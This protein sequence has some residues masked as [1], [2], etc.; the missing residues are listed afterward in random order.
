[1]SSVA[2]EQ[3]FLN[4][5]YNI[6][7]P[8]EEKEDDNDGDVLEKGPPEITTKVVTVDSFH[9]TNKTEKQENDLEK[10]DNDEVKSVLSSSIGSKGK[11]GGR[12]GWRSS[13]SRG[14]RGNSSYPR[15]QNSNEL[16]YSREGPK[17]LAPSTAS[18]HNISY[19]YLFV[20]IT[21]FLL[22]HA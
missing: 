8:E 22:Y 21:V 5:T 11:S 1:M 20:L 10:N 9:Q 19:Q 2:E 12:I 17:S 4:N 6:Y 7:P 16:Y 18:S 13:S 3:S 15:R 14:G